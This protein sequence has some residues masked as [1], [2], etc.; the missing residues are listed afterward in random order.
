MQ[1]EGLGITVAVYT[2]FDVNTRTFWCSYDIVAGFGLG[3]AT[4][5][6]LVSSQ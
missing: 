5:G 4:A 6:F 3:D 2:W 1:V